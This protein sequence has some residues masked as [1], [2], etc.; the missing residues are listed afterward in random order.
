MNSTIKICIS[1]VL[2]TWGICNP[3]QSHVNESKSS[4]PWPFGQAEPFSG[5]I[6]TD[7]PSFS[8]AVSTVPKGHIQFETGYTFTYDDRNP[9][10]TTH[11]FP[12]TLL[13]IGLTETFEA[14]VEWPTQIYINDG[15][16]VNGLN[17]LALGFKKQVIQQSKWIPQFTVVGRLFIPTG[18]KNITSNHVNPELQAVMSYAFNDTFSAFGTANIGGASNGNKRFA[19]FSS[20]LG[21]GVNLATSLSGF[22]EYFGLYPVEQ[23]I[24][25]THFIQT[26]IVYQPTYHLQLD[27]RIGTGLNHGTDDLLTGAGLSWRF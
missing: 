27:A 11:T 20:S 17:D 12:E 26:G 13:R 5:P 15:R 2:L 22:V 24:Q 7:R 23:A 4:L 6:A 14:R 1:L 21:L 18:D 8:P 25:D 3:A 10:V 16:R 9:D 19:R